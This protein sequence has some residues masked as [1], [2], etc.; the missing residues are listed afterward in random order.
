MKKTILTLAVL[1]ACNSVHAKEIKYINCMPY[2]EYKKEI[3]LD[4]FNSSTTESEKI[5]IEKNSFEFKHIGKKLGTPQEYI[6]TNNS[7]CDLL[8][9]GVVGGGKYYN[10]DLSREHSKRLAPLMKAC[11]KTWYMYVPYVNIIPAAMSDAE[12]AKFS[13]DFPKNKTIKEGEKIRI[14]CIEM[15]KD[16]RLQFVFENKVME[17]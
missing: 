17:F 11:S 2:K 5:N 16:S 7:D 1:M 6:I 14:L 10:R 13:L 3:N 4:K 9:T 8:L 15:E 12:R